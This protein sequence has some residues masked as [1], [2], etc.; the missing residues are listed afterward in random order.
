MNTQQARQK[1]PGKY[2]WEPAKDVVIYS[3]SGSQNREKGMRNGHLQFWNIYKIL[4]LVFI[5]EEIASLEI[6]IQPRKLLPN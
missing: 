2:E 1:S 6:P 4:P 3:S 5:A